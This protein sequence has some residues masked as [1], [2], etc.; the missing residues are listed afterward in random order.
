MLKIWSHL[1]QQKVLF[2]VLA[3]GATCYM[4]WP[5][6]KPVDNFWAG[7][8]GPS[9]GTA[10][11][12][13]APGPSLT[14]V[15]TLDLLD[16]NGDGNFNDTMGHPPGDVFRSGTQ[17]RSDGS[18]L[19]VRIARDYTPVASS[20]LYVID[21]GTGKTLW[22]SDK[23]MSQD[24][25]CPRAFQLYHSP[26]GFN[27]LNIPAFY[28]SHW[29]TLNTATFST[30]SEKSIFLRIGMLRHSRLKSFRADSDF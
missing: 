13:E 7:F 16:P 23:A 24:I 28:N 21:V 5:P 6:S 19:Y 12:D 14:P 4:F 22:A 18:K 2:I 10:F 1:T 25:S 30:N 26:H 11:V 17:I 9:N 27:A 8:R 3:I 29:D 15:W 20:S